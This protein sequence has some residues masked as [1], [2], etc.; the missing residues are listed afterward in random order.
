MNP[1]IDIDQH[2][3]TLDQVKEALEFDALPPIEQAARRAASQK[4]QA[5]EDSLRQFVE[6]GWDVLEPGTK[7]IPG[8]H[9]DAVCEHLQA[10][11]RG[12]D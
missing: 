12:S 7:F 5:A 2:P 4:K 10:M 3:W 1:T 6:Q 11:D 9:V 8:L